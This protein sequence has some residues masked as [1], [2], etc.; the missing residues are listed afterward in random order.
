MTLFSSD[1]TVWPVFLILAHSPPKKPDSSAP[2]GCIAAVDCWIE[3][4][5]RAVVCR[6]I[7]SG[8]VEGE[9]MGGDAVKCGTVTAVVARDRLDAL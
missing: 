5:A 2:S 7:Q 4:M 8:R 9:Y 1:A 6:E 3:C